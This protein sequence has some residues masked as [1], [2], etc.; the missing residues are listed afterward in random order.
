MEDGHRR[1]DEE[2]NQPSLIV[3]KNV[4]KEKKEKRFLLFEFF[5]GKVREL[6]GKNRLDFFSPTFLS[7][8]CLSSLLFSLSSLLPSPSFPSS[9]IGRG[10][11]L[12]GSGGD[13]VPV[14]AA[15]TEGAVM[16]LRGVA[17]VKKRD[18]KFRCDWRAFLNF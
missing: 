6:K 13:S 9:K 3:P 1:A 5:Q 12:G 10:A 17:E 4:P 18:G 2:A 8:T 16:A 14:T 11:L 15:A 7:K